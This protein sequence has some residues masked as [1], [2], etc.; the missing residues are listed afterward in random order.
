MDHERRN[1][2]SDRGTRAEGFA[3]QRLLVLPKRER[4]IVESMPVCRDL[5]PTAIG[6]FPQTDRHKVV[7]K[8]PL[9][10]HVVMWCL[11]GEGWLDVD[12]ERHIVPAGHL[13]VAPAG[14]PHAYGG[15]PERPWAIDWVHVAGIRSVDYVEAI[16]LSRKR[17]VVALPSHPE[18]H[19]LFE[20]TL[21]A[22]QRGHS[23]G[24]LIYTCTQLAALMGAW[25]R[26]RSHHRPGRHSAE[27]RVQECID[28]LEHH[29]ER[30]PPLAQ[31]AAEANLST[32]Y[33]LS[34]FRHLTGNPP[35]RWIKHVRMQKACKML[36]IESKLP[37]AEIARRVGYEDPA[38]FSR[39]FRQVI[40]ISPR[41]YRSRSSG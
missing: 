19:D 31:L 4:D 38:Y 39:S 1:H 20:N 2:R 15:H 12:G 11:G 5:H 13:S 9:N 25:A 27:A 28:R 6:S 35:G 30:D 3:S 41:A 17:P 24:H 36:V 33:F 8:K 21:A 18:L 32:S 10:E 37:I 29:P 22:F 40:G 34:V 23:S 14:E 7:R 16:G 26:F